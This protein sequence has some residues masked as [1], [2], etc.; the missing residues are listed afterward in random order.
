MTCSSAR[1][2]GIFLDVSSDSLDSHGDSGGWSSLEIGSYVVLYLRIGRIYMLP[3]VPKNARRLLTTAGR[4]RL[5]DVTA[6]GQRRHLA[7]RLDR[8][9][10]T[11]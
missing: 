8:V 5:R 1:I 4:A 3:C 10:A 11:H 7:L 2:Q 9:C 6:I